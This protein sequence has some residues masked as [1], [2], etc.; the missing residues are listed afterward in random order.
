[1]NFTDD[2]YFQWETGSGSEIAST[3]ESLV[4]E[5]SSARKQINENYNIMKI[6]V[7]QE[8]HQEHVTSLQPRPGIVVKY[9]LNRVQFGLT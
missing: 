8:T 6:K 7:E 4:M 2:S 3:S 5:D 9:L 1:M